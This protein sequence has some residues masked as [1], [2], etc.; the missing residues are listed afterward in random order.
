[1]IDD[2]LA[3]MLHYKTMKLCSRSNLLFTKDSYSSW[4]DV[5][6]VSK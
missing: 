5:V 3:P 6:A 4:T 2:N 1:M